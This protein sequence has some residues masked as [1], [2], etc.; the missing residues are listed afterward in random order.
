M[1][2]LGTTRSMIVS[3]DEGLDELSLAGGNE[4]AD[5]LGHDFEMHRFD[6]AQAGLPH[7]PIEAIRGGDATHNA[8]ALRALLL[9]A[10]GPYRDAV[11]LN[12]AAALLIAGEVEDWRAGVEEAAEAIDKGLAKALH[13]CWIAAVR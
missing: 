7:A 10:P 5:V 3:G 1:A 12:S 2:S 11:L 9:G 4:L 8:A 13:D 6:A